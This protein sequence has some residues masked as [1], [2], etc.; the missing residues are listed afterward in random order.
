MRLG[1][2]VSIGYLEYWI[3]ARVL[4]WSTPQDSKNGNY[5]WVVSHFTQATQM[6]PEYVWSR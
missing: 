5:G 3:G 4:L 1:F 6:Q 2:R